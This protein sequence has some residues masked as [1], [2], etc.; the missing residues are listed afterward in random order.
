MKD[1]GGVI[2]KEEGVQSKPQSTRS[3]CVDT[4]VGKEYVSIL[5]PVCSSGFD[6][7]DTIKSIPLIK[8]MAEP[9]LSNALSMPVGPI[10]AAFGCFATAQKG[11]PKPCF[12]A[13]C[14]VKCTSKDTKPGKLISMHRGR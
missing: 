9:S 2:G 6:L 13:Y 1:V 8:H 4:R 12:A 3:S 10:S 14:T 7:Y 5:C 11:Q